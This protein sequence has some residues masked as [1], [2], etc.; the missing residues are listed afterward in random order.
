MLVRLCSDEVHRALLFLC[1]FIEGL[2]AAVTVIYDA[3][4]HYFR[5]YLLAASYTLLSA[6]CAPCSPRFGLPKVRRQQRQIHGQVAAYRME[7]ER[8]ENRRREIERMLAREHRR[9]SQASVAKGRETEKDRELGLGDDSK[10]CACI[11]SLNHE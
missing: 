7:R 10:F 5:G 3:N 2:L 9:H 4:E 6:W 11:R 8:E 1:R